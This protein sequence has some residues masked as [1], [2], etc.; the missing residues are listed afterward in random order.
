MS[1]ATDA[2]P[3][4]GADDGRAIRFPAYGPID[5]ALG[6]GLFYVVVDSATPAIVDVLTEALPEASPSLVGLGLAITL[7][8]VLAVTVLEHLRRQLAALGVLTHAAVRPRRPARLHT[9]LIRLVGHLIAAVV[10][11]FVAAWTFDTALET[12]VSLIPVVAALEVEALVPVEIAVLIVFFVSFGIAARS[13][14]RLTIGSVRAVL[15]LVA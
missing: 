6:Y 15:G 14:D 5:A 1:T 9:S 8:G 3:R 2:T 7:W 11:G 13:V 10:A 4:S 12:I